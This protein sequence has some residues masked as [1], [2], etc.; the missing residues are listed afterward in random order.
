MAARFVLRRFRLIPSRIMAS[1]LSGTTLGTSFTSMIQSALPRELK[2]SQ[3]LLPMRLRFGSLIF[4]S[5]RKRPQAR[6]VPLG[7]MLRHNRRSHSLY[8]RVDPLGMPHGKEP[9]LG[10]PFY[11]RRPGVSACRPRVPGQVEHMRHAFPFRQTEGWL[12][13]TNPPF[14]AWGKIGLNGSV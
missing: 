6:I 10:A 12:H 5:L 2:F 1:M 14:A 8:R 13:E 9:I 4:F 11:R 7:A 3:N